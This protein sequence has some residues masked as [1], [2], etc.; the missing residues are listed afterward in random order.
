[1]KPPPFTYHDPTSVAEATE[2]LGRLDNALVLAGGQ[3]LMP[4]LNFRVIAPDHLIDLN[5][6]AALSYIAVAD[7]TGQFGAMTRQRDLEF[8]ADVAGHFPIVPEA[9]SHVGHRQTRNR[10]TLGG[11]LC[12]LDPSAELVNMAALHDGVL[13]AA[14]CGG[15]R[16]I[17]IAD[18]VDGVMTNALA[19]GEMLTGIR[20]AAWPAGH[21]FAFEE[22]S[23]RHG[24]FAIAAVGCLVVV[25]PNGTIARAALCVSGLGPAP[26]RLAAAEALLAGQ[27][28]SRDLFRAAAE[29]AK[30]LDVADDAFVSGAYRRQLAGVL[31][32]RAL[33]RAV[34]R[35]GER[36]VA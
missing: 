5:R 22:F 4:M 19:E 31:T 17:A 7:G 32:L 36:R 6:I 26:V 34:A 16:R 27:V 14:S 29:H 8:S 33:D 18:W 2:L 23:R 3:S 30:A 21:G 15:Q 24:D 10:G 12:H 1:M 13:E 11:S 25:A 35:T 20:L 28:P 9:L